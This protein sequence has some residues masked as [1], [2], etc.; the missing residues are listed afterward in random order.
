MSSIQVGSLGSMVYLGATAG[1]VIAVPLLDLM[2]T[3]WALLG[4]L[5][6]QIVALAL[7]TYSEHMT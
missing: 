6:V 7:F 2:P 4:C 1:S 3:R 5:I